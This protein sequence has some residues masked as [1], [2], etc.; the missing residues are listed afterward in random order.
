M[1]GRIDRHRYFIPRGLDSSHYSRMFHTGSYART[2]LYVSGWI[3]AEQKGP[4]E[5]LFPGRV[6]D[7]LASNDVVLV[8]RVDVDR[9]FPYEEVLVRLLTVVPCGADGEPWMPGAIVARDPA[10]LA[11]LRELA[12]QDAR[13]PRPP[14]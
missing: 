10:H 6:P 4:D 9:A 7:D 1:R 12:R 3:A 14:S 2:Y 5:A 11:R 8:G 13:S